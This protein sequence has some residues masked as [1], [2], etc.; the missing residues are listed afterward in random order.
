[1]EILIK[2]SKLRTEWMG[3]TE[4]QTQEKYTGILENKPKKKKKIP[5]INPEEE[6][7][8]EIQAETPEIE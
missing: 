5:I 2:K 8:W 1:M 3:L 4:E 6:K 7:A